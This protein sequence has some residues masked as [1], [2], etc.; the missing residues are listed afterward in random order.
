M[1]MVKSGGT[2]SHTDSDTIV[3]VLLALQT[4]RQTNELIG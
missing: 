4:D 2:E 1:M 3:K